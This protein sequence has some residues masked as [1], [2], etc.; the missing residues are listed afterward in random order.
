MNPDPIQLPGG[1][2]AIQWGHK[3]IPVQDFQIDHDFPRGE[4]HETL[5]FT[6][7]SEEGIFYTVSRYQCD[8]PH[9]P[10][11][12]GVQRDYIYGSYGRDSPA[13]G[14]LA[15]DGW[16][17]FIEWYEEQM[18]PRQDYFNT[19]DRVRVQGRQGDIMVMSEYNGTSHPN[20]D[21]PTDWKAG[22]LNHLAKVKSERGSQ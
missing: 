12:A 1:K 14:F 5:C 19:I 21:R 3:I 10:N 7:L 13:D 4:H 20:A 6:F 22:Y 15:W 17:E 9:C 11:C 18:L 2:H 8:N 16:D